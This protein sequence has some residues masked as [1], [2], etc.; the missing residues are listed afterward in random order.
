MDQPVKG[1]CWHAAS[2]QHAMMNH[3]DVF[4][5]WCDKPMC[6]HD[7]GAPMPGHGPLAP[8]VYTRDPAREDTEP[9]PAR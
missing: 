3:E 4:C 8:E 2:F 5:C 7:S 6:R 1:H 9:C